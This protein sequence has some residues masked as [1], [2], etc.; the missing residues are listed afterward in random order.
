MWLDLREISFYFNRYSSLEHETLVNSHN[1]TSDSDNSDCTINS[2]R[3]SPLP[4]LSSFTRYIKLD[5]NLS[6]CHLLRIYLGRSFAFFI[7]QRDERKGKLEE[8]YRQH[9]NDL[10]NLVFEKWLN[11]ASIE[12]LKNNALFMNA[13]EHLNS[14]YHEF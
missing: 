1:I 14:G 10:A 13:C 2:I 12:G 8:R 7:G 9:S 11:Q 4:I 3:V 5:R 6:G